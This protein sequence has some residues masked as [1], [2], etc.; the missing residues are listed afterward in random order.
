MSGNSSGYQPGMVSNWSFYNPVRVH[1]GRGVRERLLAEAAGK[2]C[3]VVTSERGRRQFT[4]DEVLGQLAKNCEIVW[5]DSVRSNPDIDHL[6]EQANRLGVSSFDLIIAFGG[7]SALDSAKVLAAALAAKT[8][9][10]GFSLRE[11]IAKP[12]QRVQMEAAPL[13]AIPTTSGTGSEVTPFATAWDGRNRKKLSF[14]GPNVFP[15]TALVDPALTDDLPLEAT[16]ATGLDAI[17]QAMES[18]WNKNATPLTLDWAARALALGL[19]AL[20]RLQD[21]EEETREADRN[22][23]AECSLL[24]GLAISQTQTSLCHAISYPLTIRFGLPHGLACAFTMPAV[25]ALSCKDDDGRME[26]IAH[27]LGLETALDLTARLTN[28][29]R[30]CDVMRRCH[31]FLPDLESV[32]AHINEMFAPDRAGNY[33]H[34]LRLDGLNEI[35]QESWNGT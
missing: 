34:Q 25:A 5:E 3:L 29:S 26:Y 16:I 14:S 11:F 8:T 31:Q 15:H 18:A 32:L 12:D 9:N 27:R 17:N 7:G 30:H 28:V 6:Q 1:F 13:Y 23:M 35:L 22:A 20:P 33:P 21:Q 4:Q 24:A 2:T 10:N 19:E